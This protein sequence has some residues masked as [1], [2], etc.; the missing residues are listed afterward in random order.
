VTAALQCLATLPLGVLYCLLDP[1]SD[2][3]DTIFEENAS[4]PGDNADD[5]DGDKDRNNKCSFSFTNGSTAIRTGS[6]LS[7]DTQATYLTNSSSVENIDLL[8]T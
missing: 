2:H 3:N 4:T 5:H 7:P 6:A 8:F 1:R